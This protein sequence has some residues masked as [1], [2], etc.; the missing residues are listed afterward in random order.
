MWWPLVAIATRRNPSVT[1]AYK[2]SAAF[3]RYCTY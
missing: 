3:K 2:K 1:A